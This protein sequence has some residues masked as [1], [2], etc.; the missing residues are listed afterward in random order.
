MVT[1]IIGAVFG[2]VLGILVVLKETQGEQ[3]GLLGVVFGTFMV[4][5]FGLL[6]LMISGGAAAGFGEMAHEAMEEKPQV[7]QLA[8][9]RNVDGVSGSFRGSLFLGVGSLGSQQYYFYYLKQGEWITPR[10]LKAAQGV[11]VR[12][13]DRADAVIETHEWH[14]SSWWAR[15]FAIQNYVPTTTYIKVP[16]GSIKLGY[17]I[18]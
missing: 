18:E 9:L 13:E 16:K 10:Q 5:L 12:E 2:L 15:M 8:A 4:F 6:G 14:F 17:R 3:W 11:Y 7:E 1:V